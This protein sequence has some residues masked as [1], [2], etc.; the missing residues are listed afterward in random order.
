MVGKR[1]I[2]QGIEC[3]RFGITR[4]LIVPCLGIELHEPAPEFRELVSRQ[5]RDIVLEF[6][7][8]AH[9]FIIVEAQWIG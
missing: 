6:L 9:T 4:E 8:I 2:G 5:S 3:A 7:D 1:V